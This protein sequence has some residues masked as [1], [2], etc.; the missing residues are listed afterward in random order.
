LET[1]RLAN[2]RDGTVLVNVYE[3]M[4][5]PKGTPAGS[6]RWIVQLYYGVP[7]AVPFTLFHIRYGNHP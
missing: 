3:P 4:G 6:S 7:C 2:P 5:M 1:V